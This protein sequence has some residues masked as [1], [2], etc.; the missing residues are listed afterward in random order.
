MTVSPENKHYDFIDVIVAL[1]LP[2]SV[3]ALV[4]AAALS[5]ALASP[6]SLGTSTPFSRT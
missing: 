6:R 2:A 3:V 1:I 4:L 5:S